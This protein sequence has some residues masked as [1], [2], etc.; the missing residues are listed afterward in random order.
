MISVKTWKSDLRCA[1]EDV[2]TSAPK[3]VA[4]WSESALRLPK[5]ESDR[6]E[7]DWSL[8]PDMAAMMEMIVRNPVTEQAVLAISAQS[9]KSFSLFTLSAYFGSVRA[10]NVIFAPPSDSLK[11]R[12][13][14]RFKGIVDTSALT[15]QQRGTGTTD[16][17]IVFSGANNYALFVC[18]SNDSNLV[19]DSAEVVII[20]E[21]DELHKGVGAAIQLLETRMR[22]RTN[23]KLIL[24]GT[25]KKCRGDGGMLDIYDKSKR[26]ELR[27]PCPH[28]DQFYLPTLDLLSSAADGASPDDIKL[29]L[30]GRCACPHCGGLADD[31]HHRAQVMAARWFDLDPDMP[32]VRIGFFKNVLCTVNERYST[33]LAKYLRLSEAAK[34]DNPEAVKALQAFMCDD[35]A[36]PLNLREVTTRYKESELRSDAFALR[37]VP[38]DV[39]FIVFGA[40]VGKRT[41]SIVLLGVAADGAH[42]LLDIIEHTYS[43]SDIEVELDEVLGGVFDRSRIPWS[44]NH[45]LHG[46]FIDYG[47]RPRD[48]ISLCLKYPLLR[49]VKGYDPRDPIQESVLGEISETPLSLLSINTLESQKDLDLKLSRSGQPS[50]SLT[51]PRNASAYFIQQIQN[52]RLVTEL[53]RKGELVER[54][55]K[56]AERAS[57]RVDQRDCTRYALAYTKAMGLQ[58]LWPK[59]RSTVDVARMP[60]KPMVFRRNR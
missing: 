32:P 35:M 13:Y 23:R 56:V 6:G 40:D 28:C 34:D 49:P 48:I 43:T 60:P 24:S 30:L 33:V 4:E 59:E 45:E 25:P 21:L 3:T 52:E 42:Y 11:E 39:Q 9:A 20:D 57:V 38:D 10:S 41:L 14:K 53:N 19:S 46:G 27:L 47:Y 58:T 31:S 29:R 1:L 16:Y 5:N 17:R 8:Y 54:Y 2:L 22:T 44:A 12:I 15:N 51:L 36:S 18:G 7:V 37:Q 55:A 26:Y 50:N